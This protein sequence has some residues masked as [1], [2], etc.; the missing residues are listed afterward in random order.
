E[1]RAHLAA[2]QDE[3]QQVLRQLAAAEERART[4]V[5]EA[6]A[7]LDAQQ[8]ARM[9][10]E[11]HAA[12]QA[13]AVRA[14][15]AALLAA[16]QQRAAAEAEADRLRARHEVLEQARAELAGFSSGAR[17]LL[18]QGF[19]TCGALAELLRVP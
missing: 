15:E 5:G 17:T 1:R 16:A 9:Q 8:R 14:A 6:N 18:G 3:Q 7:Y 10:A 4:T 13:E 11:A 12:E 2:S 19:P